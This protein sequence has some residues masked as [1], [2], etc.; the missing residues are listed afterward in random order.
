MVVAAGS[1]REGCAGVVLTDTKFAEAR[2][3]SRVTRVERLEVGCLAACPPETSFSRPTDADP[4][5]CFSLSHKT[6]MFYDR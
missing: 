4:T 6:E 5:I 3:T 1:L 2:Q